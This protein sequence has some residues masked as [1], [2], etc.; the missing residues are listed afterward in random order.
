MQDAD[1]QAKKRRLYHVFNKTFVCSTKLRGVYSN[2]SFSHYI[3]WIS[4]GIWKLRRW[5]TLFRG[6]I[7]AN[8]IL[9]PVKG[10]TKN[11]REK[12]GDFFG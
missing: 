9:I 11:K 12:K 2:M 1:N 5:K 4:V 3:L 10:P 8:E 6:L 7:V